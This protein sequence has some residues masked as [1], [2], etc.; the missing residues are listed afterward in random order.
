MLMRQKRAELD[1]LNAGIRNQIGA[2]RMF[3]QR[4]LR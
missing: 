3:V 2:L 4:W 1:K